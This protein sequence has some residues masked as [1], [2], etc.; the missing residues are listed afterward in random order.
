MQVGVGN[1]REESRALD[2]DSQLPLVARLRAGDPRRHDL[3][4]FL[5]EVLEDLDI[6]VVD[7]L[8]PFG[9]EAAELLALEQIIPALAFL[10][11]FLLSK[12]AGRT[13]HLSFLPMR[14]LA[15]R[16]H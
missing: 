10:T 9:G 2:G 3:A 11:V 6:L 4:V 14:C 5:D 12:P 8:H 15:F 7:L 16:I 1:E 13:G